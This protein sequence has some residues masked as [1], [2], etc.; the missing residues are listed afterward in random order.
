VKLV[1][2][3]ENGLVDD[4]GVHSLRGAEH[5]LGP[6]N[7]PEQVADGLILV[8]GAPRTHAAQKHHP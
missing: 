6:G 8:H 4:V 1:E 3:G 2:L 5:D 7:E